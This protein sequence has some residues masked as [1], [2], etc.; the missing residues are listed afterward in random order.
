LRVGGVECLSLLCEFCYAQPRRGGGVAV[1]RF[2]SNCPLQELVSK[3]R[4]IVFIV[5][6]RCF[7]GVGIVLKGNHPFIRRRSKGD[8]HIE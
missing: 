2:G 5:C 7:A 3:E 6:D 4:I 8:I 1:L